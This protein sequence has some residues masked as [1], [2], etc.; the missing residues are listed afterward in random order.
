LFSRHI[1][2]NFHAMK[3]IGFFFLVIFIFVVVGWLGLTFVFSNSVESSIDQGL[4]KA[5]QE[6]TNFEIS[7]T[8]FKKGFFSS[9]IT[10]AVTSAIISEAVDQEEGVEM[11]HQIFHGPVAMTPHGMKF[12]QSYV[13]TNL[14]RTNWKPETVERA[15]KVFGDKEPVTIL[16]ERS[17]SGAESVEAK[18]ESFSIDD[19]EMKM[20]FG[21]A[22]F[23]A[24]GKS[25]A[26]S[27][28]GNL[29][30]S[31][32]SFTSKG[33]E[34]ATGS[35]GESTGQ[36]DFQKGAHLTGDMNLGAFNVT[37]PDEGGTA[38][39]A[40]D[41]GTV[42]VNMAGGG[43]DNKLMLG[44]MTVTFSSAKVDAPDFAMDMSNFVI[45]VDSAENVGKLEGSATYSIGSLESPQLAEQ[46]G[47]ADLSIAFPMS[48]SVRYGGMSTEATVKLGEDMEKLEAA[49][50]ALKPGER[51][52]IDPAVLDSMVN[53]LFD[54]LAPGT[55]LG[56][57]VGLGGSDPGANVFADLVIDLKGAKKLPEMKTVR[58]AVNAL[59]LKLD[60]NTSE[61]A[62]EHP[63]L[64]PM[65]AQMQMMGIGK[66]T[67]GGAISASAQLVKGKL[68][69]DG[70]PFPLPIMQMIDPQLDQPIMWDPILEMIK[71]GI[72]ANA[73]GQ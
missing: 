5:N 60:L 65:L 8:S 15:Q 27:A 55:T 6:M 46:T 44:D 39:V 41:S 17:Y 67:G 42:S 23:T 37:F 32:L 70:K 12:C 35:L 36:F 34:A 51:L 40:L 4:A 24:N 14:D 69:V 68:N 31:S 66:R 47:G 7:K 33:E 30:V 28:K 52:D 13:K 19:D 54:V 45:D 18:V 21:G 71:A 56:M 43:P 25:S 48:V 3:K 29:K 63:M 49:Q 58:E 73:A 64:S 53:N 59:E 10:T 72:Q 62:F 38:K 11:R 2:E 16:T 22:L 20:D 9:E 50:A 26:G 57:A 1:S 61:A